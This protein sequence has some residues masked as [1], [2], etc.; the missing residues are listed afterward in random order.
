MRLITLR[1]RLAP[2]LGVCLL[3]ACDLL[4]KPSEAQLSDAAIATNA[5]LPED[6]FLGTL[7]GQQVQLIAHDC[8]VYSFK[9][10]AG[11]EVEWTS[12][13]ALEP[14]PFFT[15]CERQ[16][17]TFDANPRTGAVISVTATLGRRAFGSGG[18]CARGGTYRTTD[19]RTWKEI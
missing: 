19:G 9:R 1:W 15:S 12:V 18:C 6:L 8:E 13:L 16:S 2:L 5:A 3:A 7:A 4:F 17:L 14:Y 10:I 11:G